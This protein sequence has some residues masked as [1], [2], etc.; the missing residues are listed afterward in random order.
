MISGE[1]ANSFDEAKLIIRRNIK[2]RFKILK[3]LRLHHL[4]GNLHL[5]MRDI[6]V[7][8]LKGKVKILILN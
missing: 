6:L 2:R 5:E 1:C 7:L 3:V 4:G 8:Y